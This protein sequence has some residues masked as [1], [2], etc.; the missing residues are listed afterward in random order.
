MLN[1]NIVF[2]TIYSYLFRVKLAKV[3]E[4]VKLKS[5]KTFCPTDTILIKFDRQ[6][7]KSYIMY[8]SF[9]YNGRKSVINAGIH[10]GFAFSCTMRG[11]LPTGLVSSIF[12]QHSSKR[13][14]ICRLHLKI[15]GFYHFVTRPAFHEL[16]VLC[17]FDFWSEIVMV[18]VLVNYCRYVLE[19]FKIIL[20][21]YLHQMVR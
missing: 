12:T 10:T 15:R 16:F 5:R 14:S 4:V 3:R 2:R 6:N 9:L 19:L 11:Q 1:Q 13:S 20:C 21:I 18:N 17:F 8:T 7:I